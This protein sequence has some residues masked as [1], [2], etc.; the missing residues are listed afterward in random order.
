[1]N[2]SRIFIVGHSGAGKGV[3]A[4]GVAEKLSWKYIN[5]DFS[6]APSI[7]KRVTEIIGESAEN[8]FHECLSQ[9]LEYQITQKNIVV[10]TDDSLICLDKSRKI[11]S[12]E[13]VVYLKVSTSMQLQR[14]SNN[15]PLLPIADY[16]NFLEKFH[17]ER[18]SLYEQVA[19]FTVNSDD[20]DLDG[21]ISIIV[22]AVKNA[23]KN[24]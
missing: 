15:R 22:N 18:D 4:E 7:G 12:N 24:A 1:M 8:D 5:A 16:K 14:M 23:G 3:V 20:N 17:Q 21:H 11:L 10:T 6:L 9:I 13:F 2:F 19:T